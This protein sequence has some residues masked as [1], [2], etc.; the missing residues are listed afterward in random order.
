MATLTNQEIFDRVAKHLLEQGQGAMNGTHCAY[1]TDDG[2]RCAIGALLKRDTETD[3]FAKSFGFGIDDPNDQH[4]N[5]LNLALAQSY[6]DFEPTEEQFYGLMRELQKAHDNNSADNIRFILS[7]TKAVG[8]K[9]ELDTSV[10]AAV[11]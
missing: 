2:R 7:A 9:Y 1:L 4:E 8:L 11:Q 6:L 10:L 5:C 3:R